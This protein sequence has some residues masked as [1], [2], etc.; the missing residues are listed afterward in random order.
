MGLDFTNI[1][2]RSGAALYLI[3][4]GTLTQQ[5][6]L[7]RLAEELGARQL[8][9]QIIL[10]SARDPQAEKIRDFYDLSSMSFPHLL[11]VADDDRLLHSWSGA[12]L[13]TADHLA[14]ALQ[15]S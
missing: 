3:H 13:P 7:E 1:T 2:D 6:S 4:D 5:R 11:I 8:R 12:Q 15:S 10:L 9:Q 14:Y